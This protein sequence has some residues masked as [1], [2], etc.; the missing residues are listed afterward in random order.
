MSITGRFEEAMKGLCAFH[1]AKGRLRDET[2]ADAR[3]TYA[4][5]EGMESGLEGSFT[6]DHPY[7]TLP[8]NADV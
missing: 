4:Q 2:H 7:K 1:E 3:L 8:I 6:Y 5:K